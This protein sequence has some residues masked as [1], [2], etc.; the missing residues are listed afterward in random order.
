MSNTIVQNLKKRNKEFN[1]NVYVFAFIWFLA[2]NL[3]TYSELTNVVVSSALLNFFNV[4]FL[5]VM[6]YKIIALQ[7]YSVKQV[8]F[9]L[10]L[11]FI[12]LYTDRVSDM[13]V[14]LSDFFLVL[15]TQ[16]VDFKVL[17][18]K[19]YKIEVVYIAIHLVAYAF[20]WVF[21]RGRIVFSVRLEDGV[22]HYRHRLFLSHANIASMFVLWTILA[23]F[24]SEY[25]KLNKKKIVF[26]WGIYYLI[27]LLT[28]TNSGLIILSIICAL[29]L[30]KDLFKEGIDGVVTFLAKY[31]YIIMAI[32]FNFLMVIYTS[33]TGEL[34]EIWNTLNDFFTGRLLYGVYA[35]DH[36][37]FTLF[38]RSMT[39]H[40]DFWRGM[41]IDP[42]PCDNTYLWMSVGYGVFYT[43]LIGFL[44]WKCA[45]YATFEEKL[46]IIA[47]TLYSA[48]E[49]YVTYFYF[50]FTI[51]VLMGYIW[52]KRA[53]KPKM[54]R[55]FGCEIST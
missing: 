11:G 45:R 4:V 18:R 8:F 31:L 13:F 37:G 16:D 43:F 28:D 55:G 22:R 52:N 27:Y 19:V 50:N 39:F 33:L 49:L 12:T 14:F 35:Y 6:L 42:C 53:D 41:W 26:A 25:D 34:K 15:A 1:N 24:Y 51:V 7:K 54:K 23:Y 2:K 29:L 47:Y 30:L 36:Y 44:F 38:G 5:I 20:M 46:L 48:M 9:F 17:I 10:M 40:K 32:F 21:D 3:I